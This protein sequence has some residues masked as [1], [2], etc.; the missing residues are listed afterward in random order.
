MLFTIFESWALFLLFTSRS[1][2][3]EGL[4]TLVK[5]KNKT[6]DD[7]FNALTTALTG[8]PFNIN[9]GKIVRAKW[10]ALW[11]TAPNVKAGKIDRSP[12]SVAAVFADTIGPYDPPPCPDS[13]TQMAIFQKLTA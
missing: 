7:V 2:L 9:A 10:E 1:P 12:A 8:A 13:N 4:D 5:D 6:L 3:V 11:T